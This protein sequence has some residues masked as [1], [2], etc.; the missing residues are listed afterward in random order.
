MSVDIDMRVK[1]AECVKNKISGPASVVLMTFYD[2]IKSGLTGKEEIIEALEGSRSKVPSDKIKHLNRAIEMLKLE[3][4][5]NVIV[6]EDGQMQDLESKPSWGRVDE[7]RA[8]KLYNFMKDCI[9]SSVGGGRKN[10][11]RGKKTKKISKK[12]KSKKRR[13]K[14]YTK[15]KNKVR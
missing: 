12:R 5:P 7:N 4:V 1:F 13:S 14:K 3:Y 2:I 9:N 15:R 11:Y 8:C 10:K 6:D